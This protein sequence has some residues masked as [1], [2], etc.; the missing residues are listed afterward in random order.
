MPA[1]TPA[2]KLTPA[3]QQ[4]VEDELLRA[5]LLFDQLVEGTLDHVRKALPSLPP[6]QRSAIGDLMQA[7]LQHRTRLAD[8]FLQSLQEQVQIEL[9]QQPTAL[10]AHK[11]PP[12]AV[13]L[14]LVDED[15]VAL[16]V[17]LSH[18]IEEVK[19]TAEF[20]VRELQAFVSALV[21]DLDVARDHNPFRPD[22]WA[23]AVWAAAQALPL[24]RGH[25]VTF[26][27]HASSSLAQLLRRSYAASCSRLE[28]MGFEPA[29]YRT[30]ILPA[31]S[32]RGGRPGDTTFSPDLHRMRETMPAP[33]DSRLSYDGQLP[34]DNSRLRERWTDIARHTSNRADR[35]SIELVSRLFDAM[36]HDDRVPADVALLI[37][38]LHGPAMRLTLR[39]AGMMDQAKHPLWR[40][41][42]RLAYEAEMAPDPQDPE[43]VRL[44]KITQATIDQLASEPE[45]S[46]GLYKWANERLDN[47]LRQ[48]LARR[49]T[50]VASHVGALQKL[51]DKLAAGGAAVPSTLHGM[52]DVPQMDTVPAALIPEQATDHAAP[53]SVDQW[54]DDLQ[55]GDWLR[56]FLQGRW[57]H[58][59]LLWPGERR[60]VWLLGDGASDATWAV[61]RGALLLMRE[62]GLMKSLKQRSIVGSAALRVEHEVARGAAA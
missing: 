52:L 27:R 16:D 42:N 3:M 10:A 28:G 38:R 51:E 41:V 2:A 37:S 26:L 5:P 48:R 11:A 59:Q 8:A 29:S 9:A 56:V 17:E 1:P 49:L 22:T 7:L 35:Q 14:A 43:R 21:G 6:A 13:A 61:R 36:Q 44:L 31:G 40:L 55:P 25:R 23:R 4:F 53:A 19:S 50:A 12:K 20:E 54:L 34:P 32:R 46:T 47:F 24:S 30:M 33:L 62:Q 15:E 58:A 45:Q 57:V 18:M 60:E 39:D